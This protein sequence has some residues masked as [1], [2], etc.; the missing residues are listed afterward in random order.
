M[1]TITVPINDEL[2]DFILSMIEDNK[3]ETKAGVVRMALQKLRE[4]QLF[5]EIRQAQES[6][7]KY[8]TFKGD[9]DELV[10]DI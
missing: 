6:V 2:N 1:T 3:A 7:K 10:K 8:G 4:E 5:E 9:L